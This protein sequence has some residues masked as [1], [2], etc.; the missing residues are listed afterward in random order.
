MWAA[1]V[2][3]GALRDLRLMAENRFTVDIFDGLDSE[4]Y[5]ELWILGGG[6]TK[7][8]GAALLVFGHFV[9][10]A[11]DPRMFADAATISIRRAIAIVPIPR[12]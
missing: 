3:E 8:N 6:G 9:G 5:L 11:P 10:I 7:K 2:T 4:T 12:F 1:I